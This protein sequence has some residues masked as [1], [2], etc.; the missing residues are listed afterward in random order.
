M[1]IALVKCSAEKACKEMFTYHH[2]VAKQRQ[3]GPVFPKKK[4]KKK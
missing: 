1:R 2:L 4:R 3:R